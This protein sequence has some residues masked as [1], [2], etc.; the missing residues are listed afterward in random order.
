MPRLPI[1]DF[2]REPDETAIVV[3]MRLM[4]RGA[5]NRF[6]QQ[7]R[8]GRG[9]GLLWGGRLWSV[10]EHAVLRRELGISLL[11]GFGSLWVAGGCFTETAFSLR[12]MAISPK[13]PGV[14]MRA[15]F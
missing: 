12:A 5:P 4:D 13:T 8:M 15:A 9:L 2:A 11:E 6:H 1:P 3:W 7:R 10:G 14:A